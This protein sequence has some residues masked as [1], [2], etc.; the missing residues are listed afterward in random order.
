[1]EQDPTRQG[2][3]R[4]EQEQGVFKLVS[5]DLFGGEE[6]LFLPSPNWGKAAVV[7]VAMCCCAEWQSLVGG[8]GS[9]N[10]RLA[11][12]VTAAKK[13]VRASNELLL[14]PLKEKPG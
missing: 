8:P 7:V 1:M 10:L 4:C 2:Q 5:G 14:P 11:A 9:D 3:E 6:Y 13:G 12:A